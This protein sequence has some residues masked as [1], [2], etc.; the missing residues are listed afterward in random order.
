MAAAGAAINVRSISKRFRALVIPKQAT[1]KEAIVRGTLFLRDEKVRF[2]QALTE[3]SFD[4]PQGGCIG[5]VGRNGSGKSTLMRLLAGVMAADSGR[6]SISGKVAPLLSLGVGFHPDLTGRE[7]ARISGLM[8][9]LHPAEVERSMG[10]V[11]DFSELGEFIDTPVRMYSTGMYMRLAYAV[12]VS[13]N[14]DILLLDEVFAVGDAAFNDKCR[15]HMDGLRIAGKTIVLVSHDLSV[16]ESFCDTA[17]WLEHGE[18]RSMGS[19]V[20]VVEAYRT[21]VQQ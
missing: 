2:V 20:D 21:A 15:R 19:A 14:P 16:I 17:L 9:G 18:I 6:I 10:A 1:L 7:N 4:V 5:I 3:V 12:A 11:I 13:V 8:L